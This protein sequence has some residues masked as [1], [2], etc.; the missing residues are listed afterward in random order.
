M[1]LHELRNWR[2]ITYAKYTYGDSEV[3]SINANA[4]NRSEYARVDG[5]YFSRMSKQFHRYTDAYVSNSTLRQRAITDYTCGKHISSLPRAGTS[6]IFLSRGQ[7]RESRGWYGKV[8]LFR[9]ASHSLRKARALSAQKRGTKTSWDKNRRKWQQICGQ[10]TRN[11]LKAPKRELFH[12][13]IPWHTF[14]F[15]DATVIK[16]DDG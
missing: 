4:A 13:Y 15:A 9:I 16:S 10:S 11:R 5:K 3:K 2:D 1:K 7:P 14:I 12:A 8:Q 6:G